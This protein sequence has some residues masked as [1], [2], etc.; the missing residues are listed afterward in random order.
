MLEQLN[1]NLKKDIE[2]ISKISIVPNILNVIC[3]TT[4]M[5]FA[6]VAR[7]TETD[8]TACSVRDDIS[9]GLKPGEGLQIETTF[10]NQIRQSG[11]AVIIDHVSEDEY[12]K[13]HL[14]PI[15]YGFQSYISIPIY[16]KDH[17][18][19]G[20]LCAIDLNPNKL[21]TPRVIEM[22]NLFADLIS[23]HLDVAEE[24]DSSKLNLKLQVNF[25]NE[26]ERKIEERTSELKEKNELLLNTN[27]K[28]QEFNYI[29]SHD[30]QEPL[31]KIQTFVSIIQNRE[32]HSFS[33][34]SILY[35]NKIRKAAERM[36]L[37][38]ND[39]LTYSQTDRVERK[40]EFV[41]LN[42]L[43]TEVLDDLQDEI[44]EK[45]AQLKISEMCT[46][47]LIPFQMR[48]L[49]YNIIG[50][51]L[52]YSSKERTP[53]IKIS[54]QII[55][56]NENLPNLP[57]NKTYCQIIISDNGIGFS[58]QYGKKIFEVFQRLHDNLE[59]D[60]T[61]IGLAIVK[62]IV[63][64]HKG[65]IEANGTVNEGSEFKITFPT[66]VKNNL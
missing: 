16:R 37:L 54:S 55:N 6:A 3:Q 20:T 63:E 53:I 21:N 36:Q 45:S 24:L 26:L 18:F 17:S 33:N 14:I 19:F 28:L 47:E 35:F 11:K 46:V 50:N 30:L 12:Y 40:L 9:F 27:K 7:V 2:N 49:F 44:E 64:N 65:I 62:K 15:Q 13:C 5:G 60:G 31:R 61:G 52:K 23:F 4:G 56:S 1:K 42:Q 34:K 25:N 58:Q 38:I 48:Q 22:F 66:Q 59:F 41:D 32:S 57:T 43:L 8:W 51:A 10:C 39:L 29:S